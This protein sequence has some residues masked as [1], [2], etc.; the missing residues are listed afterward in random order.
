MGAGYDQA[1]LTRQGVNRTYARVRH[2]V[3]SKGSI[4]TSSVVL[5]VA[6]RR[7]HNPADIQ[8]VHLENSEDCYTFS[9]N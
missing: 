9:F 7:E 3:R 6:D 1:I 8:V 2:G 4:H 5:E